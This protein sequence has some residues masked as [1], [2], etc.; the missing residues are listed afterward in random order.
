MREDYKPV[1]MEE[2]LKDEDNE[3]EDDSSTVD[4]ANSRLNA[5]AEAFLATWNRAIP[6]MINEQTWTNE[7]DGEDETEKTGIKSRRLLFAVPISSDDVSISSRQS[8]CTLFETN[9]PSCVSLI[10]VK[11][12]EAIIAEVLSGTPGFKVLNEL[13]VSEQLLGGGLAVVAFE[14]LPDQADDQQLRQQQHL[15]GRDGGSAGVMESDDGDEDEDGDRLGEAH[16]EHSEADAWVSFLAKWHEAIPHMLR[17]LRV[18]EQR[19]V[20]DCDNNNEDEEK[21]RRCLLTV[22]ISGDAVSVW[23][24]SVTPIVPSLSD[25]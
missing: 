24:P 12:P 11:Q 23:S 22:P 25:H 9:L 18:S 19:W 21:R 13:F 3:D 5:E 7:R 17:D 10:I 15:E 16:S 6:H 2:E 20:D 8:A 1:P 4:V 14:S